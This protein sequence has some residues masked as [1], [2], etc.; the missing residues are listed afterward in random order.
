VDLTTWLKIAAWSAAVFLLLRLIRVALD[1]WNGWR[2][3]AA[4][5][6]V[7]GRA[8]LQLHSAGLRAAPRMEGLLG[9]REALVCGIQTDWPRRGINTRAELRLPMPSPVRMRIRREGTLALLGQLARAGFKPDK[10]DASDAV[11]LDGDKEAIRQ[12]LAGSLGSFLRTMEEW[13][14]EI[15]G[16]RVALERPGLVASDDRLQGDLDLLADIARRLEAAAG[17]DPAG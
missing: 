9:D 5:R 12:L 13:H 3:H 1:L 7:A 15:D 8:G 11:E 16:E 2:V 4:W 17:A 14:L 6:R 10:V